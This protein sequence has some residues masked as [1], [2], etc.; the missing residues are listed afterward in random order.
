LSAA[1]IAA[2][3]LLIVLW[4]RSYY[5]SEHVIVPGVQIWLASFK[6]TFGFHT[7]PGSPLRAL[8]VEGIP[9]LPVVLLAGTL[10]ALPWV[11]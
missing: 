7:R 1:G 6:G 8:S 4:V 9:Y 5:L 3:G 11:T 10:A 2:C